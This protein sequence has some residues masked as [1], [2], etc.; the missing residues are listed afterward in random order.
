M[1]DADFTGPYRLY[2]RAVKKG[3]LRVVD[4]FADLDQ[5]I[6]SGRAHL[7]DGDFEFIV[8]DVPTYSKLQH[9]CSE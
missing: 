2:C 3:E 1:E 7:N 8:R 5:A 9:E 4:T 6:E